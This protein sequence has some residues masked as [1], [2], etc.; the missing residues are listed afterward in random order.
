MTAIPLYISHENRSI[1]V[2]VDALFFPHQLLIF[3]ILNKLSCFV[4]L[5]E[6]WLGRSFKA[7]QQ[8][9]WMFYNPNALVFSEARAYPANILKIHHSLESKLFF[10]EVWIRA[11][12]KKLWNFYRHF[13]P[14]GGVSVKEFKDFF[15]P[16][17]IAQ[18]EF[19][20]FLERGHFAFVYSLSGSCYFMVMP[21]FVI[22]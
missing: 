21:Q 17:P 18:A 20:Y 19:L 15:N 12:M 3:S 8:T 6:S 11:L 14:I 5:I 7:E 10:G 1:R 22:V 9:F 16:R 13:D 2:P 4:N